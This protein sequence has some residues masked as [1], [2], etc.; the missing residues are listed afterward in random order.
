MSDQPVKAPEMN[1]VSPYLVVSDPK[2]AVKFYE[3]A[4]GF[5]TNF[6]MPDKSGGIMHAEMQ[7]QDCVIMLGPENKEWPSAKSLSGSP[8]TLYVYVDGV[9]AFFERVKAAGAEI[10]Q[11][12][13]TQFYGDRT[14]TVLCPERHAWTFAQKVA[15]FDPNNVPK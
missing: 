5:K 3:E 11:E 10:R 12:P 1:W 6:T 13:K 7:Y 15:E 8:I 14:F 4:F 2:S 9:D